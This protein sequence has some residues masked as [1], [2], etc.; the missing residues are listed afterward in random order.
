MNEKQLTALLQQADDAAVERIGERFPATDEATKNRIWE[1]LCARQ[2][3]AAA[4]DFAEIEISV[5]EPAKPFRWQGFAAA[6]AA[7]L[8]IAGAAVFALQRMPKLPPET[9]P[10]LSITATEASNPAAERTTEGAPKAPPFTPSHAQLS[11]RAANYLYETLVP[12]YGMSDLPHHRA[13]DESDALLPVPESA[14][15]I[16]S[17]V[18]YDFTGDGSSDLLTARQD[19]TA[20]ILELYT[21][22]GASYQPAGSY[23]CHTGEDTPTYLAQISAQDGLLLIRPQNRLHALNDDTE[24]YLDRFTVLKADS[25]GFSESAVLE[26]IIKY[27]P[28]SEP[29]ITFHYK[30]NG[31]EPIAAS[32]YVDLEDFEQVVRQSN[33]VLRSAGV[34][35]PDAAVLTTN[36]RATN[37]IPT[38]LGM[39]QEQHD[40]LRHIYENGHSTVCIDFTGLQRELPASTPEEIA[41]RYLRTDLIP[42]YGLSDLYATFYFPDDTESSTERQL[43]YTAQGIIGALVRDLTGD[44]IPELMT[45]RAE[46]TCLVIDFYRIQDGTCIPLTSRTVQNLQPKIALQNGQLLIEQYTAAGATYTTDLTVLRLTDTGTEE[47]LHI[48][49]SDSP[50]RESFTIDGTETAGA[51]DSFDQDEVTQL[52]QQALERVGLR[53][54]YERNGV[55][56]DVIHYVP[57]KERAYSSLYF[58]FS[59]SGQLLSMGGFGAWLD[60]Y[61]SDYTEMQRYFLGEAAADGLGDDPPESSSA[62]ESS[63]EYTTPAVEKAAYAFVRDVLIPQYG[64]SD[65]AAY[66]DVDW[67]KTNAAQMPP[68]STQGIV[69]A[70]TEQFGGSDLL[71]TV[72]AEDWSLLLDFYEP[73]GDSFRQTDSYTVYTYDRTW[74]PTPHIRRQGDLIVCSYEWMYVPGCSHYG[75]SYVFLRIKDGKAEPVC[76]L[77]SGRHPGNEV[78]S[79]NGSEISAAEGEMDYAETERLACEALDAAGVNYRSLSNGWGSERSGLLY[80]LQFE[81]LNYKTIVQMLT[82]DNGNSI[83]GNCGNIFQYFSKGVQP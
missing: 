26:Q 49:Y 66:P 64:L 79:V 10:G 24:D 47:T 81:L 70:V 17:A 67:D 69:S 72:R 73:D 34:R 60:A 20:C 31:S 16:L 48:F 78:F 52:V 4:S 71:V 25:A 13:G 22:S 1:K 39:I 56:C 80:G 36:Y 46:R 55:H 54:E 2:G 11:D 41:Y 19:E 58:D 57:G 74:V 43:P 29:R 59:G 44:G 27:R 62:S 45:I 30:I 51:H 28:G 40:I 35:I 7:L 6:A 61:Y 77:E 33:D 9:E 15:G 65:Q 14:Q 76:T 18:E 53:C 21:L 63:I 8:V 37:V 38:V 3:S 32:D 23:V 83:F 82:D 50:E 12:Q 5:A 75:N 42:A 68:K